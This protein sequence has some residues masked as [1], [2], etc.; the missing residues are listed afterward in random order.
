[1]AKQNLIAALDIGGGKITAVAATVDQQKNVVQ[2]LAGDEFPCEGLEGGIVSDIREVTTTIIETIN[3]L[4]EKTQADI[5]SLYIALRGE[6]IESFTSKGTFNIV[7]LVAFHPVNRDVEGLDEPYNIRYG[8]AQ[9][10][11]HLFAVGFVF[12]VFGLPLLGAGHVEG[13]ADVGGFLVFQNLVERIQKAHHRRGVEAFRGHSRVL[14]HG[15]ESPVNQGV[16]IK[17]EKF[18]IGGFHGVSFLWC[19]NTKF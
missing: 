5:N 2:I 15:E 4:E 1:M 16:G 17:E 12:A 10:V 9:V 18:F 14:V 13:H 6:H 11:G 8:L 7:G 19:K 3:Y